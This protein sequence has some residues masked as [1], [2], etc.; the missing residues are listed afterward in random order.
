[1]T[2]SLKPLALCAAA[3]LLTACGHRGGMDHDMH[4]GHA[5]PKGPRA[6]ATL[7][8][9][10]GNT[11]AGTVHFVQHGDHVMATVR[12][13]G[14]KANSEH[15][16]HVHEKG[17]CS[18]GDGMSTGGHFNPTGQPH[19]PQHAAHHAGDMPALKADANGVAEMRF[20]ISGVTI[21]SGP[22]DLLGRG[23]IVHAQPDDY[24]TQPTG[25]SGARIAC[26]V[27]QAA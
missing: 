9:T 16:F 7:A 14:L 20:H 8:P 23:L 12:I 3:L 4:A 19:G 2:L 13:T 6:L 17:D 22:A 27:I 18:S 11:T 25:N 24:S 21:G 10:K 26:A 5:E 15:G 1:M